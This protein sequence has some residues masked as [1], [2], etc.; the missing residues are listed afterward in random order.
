MKNKKEYTFL[1]YTLK[2]ISYRVMGP[3]FYFIKYLLL[4]DIY[5]Y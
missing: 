1:K 3:L 5:I 2:T 4:N